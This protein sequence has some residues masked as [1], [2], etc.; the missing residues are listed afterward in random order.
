MENVYATLG[1]THYELDSRREMLEI[2]LLSFLA[3]SI[4]FVFP[5][6]QLLTGIV[7]NSF[8]VFAALRIRGA[9]VLPVVLLPS[10]GALASGIVFGPL[11]IFLIYTIPSIWIGNF[12]FVYGIKHFAFERG[13]NFWGAGI[14]SAFVKSVA[15][16]I[17]AYALFFFGVLPEA[18]LAPMGILQF[19]TAL[20]AVGVAGIGKE[21]AKK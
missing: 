8:L 4:P 10:L 1:K 2:V 11:T 18:M 6:P 19:A 5:G 13:M 9:G 3:F 21:I 20:G 17:P 7:V 14:A 12:L 15:I 16:F